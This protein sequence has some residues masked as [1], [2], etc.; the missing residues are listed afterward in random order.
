MPG[1]IFSVFL[2]F[3]VQA[4]GAS[5][6]VPIGTLI[7]QWIN[8]SLLIL[9]IYFSQRRR[10]VEFFGDKKEEFLRAVEESL[11][12]RKEAQK[13]LDEISEKLSQISETFDQQLEKAKEDAQK[14]YADQLQEARDQGS[15]W[16]QMA[17]VGFELQMRKQAESLKK[18]A[19]QKSIQWAQK[20]LKKDLRSEHF[21]AWNTHFINSG[22]VG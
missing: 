20:S 8:L 11:Q 3:S 12:S 21:K 7:S 14:A 17:Q 15:H 1:L 19:F 18:E 5:G 22:K 4:F 16:K 10:V 9:L 13:V 2:L 6:S